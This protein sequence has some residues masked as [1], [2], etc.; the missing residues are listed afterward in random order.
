MS[1]YLLVDTH[2]AASPFYVTGGTL[3][4]DALSYVVRQADKDL[5][6][7]L[8]NSQF[9]YVLT[10][11]QMGKS[12]LM[13]RTAARLREAAVGIALLD[14]T[15]IGQNLTAEQWYG[16][17]LTQ[18]GEQLDL[19][20]EL[21][22]FWDNHPKLG[23]L[24]RW[25]HC[26]RNVLLPHYPGAIVIFIDEID[27]VQS[28]PF[29]TDEFF[30]AIREVY[31]RR[32]GEPELQRLTFCLLG[33]AGPS[34]LIRDTR[35]TP[36]NVGRRIELHD[37]SD[38]EAAPLSEGLRQSPDAGL[39][40]LKRILYWTNG[41]PYLTQR[42]CQAV[43]EEARSATIG[44]VDRLCRELFLSDKALE[45]DDN[46]LFVRER[47]L[48]SEV[49]LAGLLTIYG[50]VLA[51]TRVP[52]DPTNPLITVLRLS[53]IIGVDGGTLRVRNQIYEQAFG[54]DW[55][56]E[57]MPDAEVRRQRDAYRRGVVRATVIAAVIIAAMAGLAFAAVWQR[58]RAKTQEQSNRRLLY[59]AHMT[60]A[61]RDW[62]DSSIE[63]VRELLALHTPNS[64]QNDLR[65]F[66][67]YL[68][69]ALAHQ[70]RQTIHV[71]GGTRWVAF[72]PDFK[73]F[74]TAEDKDLKLWD[75]ATGKEIRS[76]KEEG[77][78]GAV[79]FSRDGRLLAAGSAD[80][81]IRLWNIADGR[82]VGRLRG[83][84]RSLIAL[85]FSPDGKV[86]ASTS[87]DQTARLW[88]VATGTELATL[89][90]HTD[91]V[92]SIAF[93]SDGGKVLTGSVD[94]TARVWNTR[95][96]KELMRLKEHP[97]KALSTPP[98]IWRV[99][100][101]PDDSRILAVGNFTGVAIWDA[102]TGAP[103]P[104]LQGHQSWIQGLAFSR[105]GKLLAT[106]SG[107]RT[108]R[109]W[110]VATW[111]LIKVFTGHGN[112]VVDLSFSSDGVTLASASSDETI[113]LWDVAAAPNPLGL[114][115]MGRIAYSPDGGTLALVGQR[116]ITL[117]DTK[118]WKVTR[119]FKTRGIV[120]GAIVYSPDGKLL[121]FG[122]KDETASLW[123]LSSGGERFVLRGHA[124]YVQA[125]AFSPDGKLL[126]TGGED[127]IIRLWQ[128]DT[129]Q[130]LNEMRGHTDSVHGLAFS[131]DGKLLVSSSWDTT[132]KLW[133]VNTR[134]E[135]AT[136]T[137]H[138]SESENVAFSPDGKLIASTSLD[139]TIKLWDAATHQQLASLKGHAG[140]IHGLAFSP[141]GK[142]LASGGQDFTLRLWDV[143]VGQEMVTFR[144]HLAP[145]LSVAF[146]PDGGTLVSCGGDGLLRVWR[147][148]TEEEVQARK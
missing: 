6:E 26:I 25:M 114:K 2:R 140:N 71:P 96:G 62:R 61:A 129:G 133:D 42:L 16:G 34:D 30:G 29:S 3:S 43:A 139:S 107:D 118:T 144:R 24:Q 112:Q 4:R 91:E 80:N 84:A 69:W 39:L 142:R 131:P 83:H 85:V 121:A 123:D 135:V 36:F 81:S 97:V 66:E 76:L 109:L 64:G 12:S 5:Y 55:V 73:T 18:L 53:G 40:L 9:C 7:G 88:D 19:E 78:R 15:A 57:N 108:V 47:L 50:K 41:H 104:G 52:D 60:L 37:F 79:A 56:M 51:H 110:D 134:R 23:P 111:K 32:S 138:T 105:D 54:R 126:A 137:G 33:V 89:K 63:H 145:I 27:A 28:L 38:A 67:W 74:A 99:L 92:S 101:S 17:L 59:S 143:A 70:D 86:L 116:V 102:A 147:G 10:S 124:G 65:G 49:D 21:E 87:E 130:E 11:R 132:L 75:T 136:L 106:G 20:S 35:T 44:E 103:L 141:D 119:T 117:W 113:K 13:V 46:L 58:N 128:V 100:F 82:G 77:L 1:N 22:A 72:A 68:L 148:A 146:S 95:T 127:R 120:T 94:E 48:H 31:N 98:S 14:L 93:S 115:G 125:L 122:S 90:G 45:R 8:T